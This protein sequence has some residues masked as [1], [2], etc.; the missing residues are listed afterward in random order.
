MVYSILAN[1]RAFAAPKHLIACHRLLWHQC[2]R[3]LYRRGGGRRESGA[4]LLGSI[5]KNR[6]IVQSVIYYDDLDPNCLTGAINLD[7]SAYP[8]LWRICASRGQRVVADVHTH[9]GKPWQSDVDSSNPMLSEIGHV[10]IIVPNF[11]KRVR[12]DK[13]LG[14]F[15]YRGNYIWESHLRRSAAE[16][17]YVGW[18]V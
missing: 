14:V 1:I 10:A 7:G 15:V 6:R 9:P 11:A 17:F 16:T 3:E 5:Y 18:F 13:E 4:F 2:I 8:R 12:D